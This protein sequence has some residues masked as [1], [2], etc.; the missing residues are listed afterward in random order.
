[1]TEERSQSDQKVIPKEIIEARIVWLRSQVLQF[2]GALAEQELLLGY[3][4][5]TVTTD[6]LPT[7]T[8][9][10]KTDGGPEPEIT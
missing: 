10:G 7:T 3:L 6:P 5:G 1:M 4:D 2:S 9:E 8:T